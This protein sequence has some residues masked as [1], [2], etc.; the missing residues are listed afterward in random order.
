[1]PEIWGVFS[2]VT[3]GALY[4]G[5]TGA[6]GL[7]LINLAYGGLVSSRETALKR[8]VFTLALIAAFAS[9]LSFSL[10]GAA[11]S[12]DASGLVD[13]EMLSLLWGTPA[14]AALS[15]RLI[16]TALIFAGLFLPVTGVWVSLAGGVLGLWSFA[17]I[18]HLMDVDQ[19]GLRLLLLLHLL[20]LSFWI[21]VLIPLRSLAVRPQECA[22][23]A[24]LG[25][26]FGVAAAWI[27]PL[28]I[29]AGGLIAWR[30]LGSLSAIFSTTY[31]L[32]LLL[33]IGLVAL[34]LCLA[35][36]NKL[37]FIPAMRSGDA[38]AA[39]NL[40]RAIDLE[41][42]VIAMVFLVTATLTS[43]FSLPN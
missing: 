11:L 30:L 17:E 1:M 6:T 34:L 15:A 43:V 22:A 25:H 37:R 20:G 2:I 36:A 26:R 28:L 38:A 14:G 7:I 12:G 42:C 13:T 21:G 9:I 23:A 19:A 3:K 24:T 18:G 4:V 8:L 39:K 41:I 31:G 5:M 40:V 27:V 33:K 16:G 29:L 35:L 32:A 10:R